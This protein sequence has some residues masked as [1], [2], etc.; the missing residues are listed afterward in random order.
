[1]LAGGCGFQLRGTSEIPLELDPLF[2]QDD[3]GTATGRALLDRL[4][5]SQVRITE[6][7]QAARAVVRIL[8]ENRDS[9][10]AAVDRN[11]KVLAYDLGLQVTFDALDA[12]GAPLV[13]AQ[14]V[15]L[16]RTFDNPDIEVLGKR[17]ETEMVYRDME[18]E[19][20]DRLVLRLRAALR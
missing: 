6:D 5:G 15:T 1:M 17:E 10:V 20:A 7:R 13:P 12:A 11:G 19:A 3:A 2:I 14:Q 9:R 18:E 4:Q 8:S 16:M